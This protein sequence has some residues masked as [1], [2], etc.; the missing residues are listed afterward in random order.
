MNAPMLNF[1]SVCWPHKNLTVQKKK[2][3]KTQILILVESH[4]TCFAFTLLTCPRSHLLVVITKEV[5]A[6]MCKE[7]QQPKTDEQIQELAIL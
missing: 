6:L 7:S 2:I 3:A 5:T 4:H 1:N